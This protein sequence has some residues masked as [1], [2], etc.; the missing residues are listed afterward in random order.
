MQSFDGAV[1]LVSHDQYFVNK[2]AEEVWVVAGQKV[3]QVA[4][5][6]VYRKQQ[7]QQLKTVD[8]S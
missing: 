7:L 4:S 3:K 6:D 8:Y 1:I 5:F 2:V